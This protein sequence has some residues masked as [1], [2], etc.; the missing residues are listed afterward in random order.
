[1]PYDDG[2]PIPI[3]GAF[4]A[5]T[6]YNKP[7]FNYFLEEQTFDLEKILAPIDDVK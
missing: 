3:E 1:M 5:S 4:Y 6:S 7:I 2:S